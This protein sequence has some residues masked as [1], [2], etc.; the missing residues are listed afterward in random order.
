[1][2]AETATLAAKRAQVVQVQAEL[3][4]LWAQRDAL[5]AASAEAERL[6]LALA[7]LQEAGIYQYRHP[8]Q[9]AIAYK[10]KLT[11]LQALIKDA[12]KAGTAVRG[13]TSWTVNGSAQSGAKMVREFSKLM[14]RAYNN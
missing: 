9:D 7:K 13:A 6:T 10:A 4:Q 1:M 2:R 11:G 5:A 14:L 8:L 3:Q 12:V